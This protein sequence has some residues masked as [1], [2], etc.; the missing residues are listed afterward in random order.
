MDKVKRYGQ[1]LSKIKVKFCKSRL[2]QNDRQTKNYILN[3]DREEFF[4]TN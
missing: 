1:C 2:G 4:Y 3:V